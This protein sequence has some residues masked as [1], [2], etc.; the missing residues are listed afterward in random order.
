MP[1]TYTLIKAARWLGVAPWDL[2]RAPTYWRHW[3]L[4]AIE[5]D[6][7]MHELAAG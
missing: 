1:P 5:A 7:L 2:A 4:L 6:N 3:T